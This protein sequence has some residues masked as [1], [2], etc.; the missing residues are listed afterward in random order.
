MDTSVP[1]DRDVFR[2]SREDKWRPSAME[3]FVSVSEDHEQEAM[4]AVDHMSSAAAPATACIH[5]SVPEVNSADVGPAQSEEEKEE[6]KGGES[7]WGSV[8]QGLWSKRTALFANSEVPP[9]ENE[10]S[11]C[12]VGHIGGVRGMPKVGFVKLWNK[13]EEFWNTVAQTAAAKVAGGG[14]GLDCGGSAAGPEQRVRMQ[15]PL[16]FLS[17]DEWLSLLPLQVCTEHTWMFQTIF[18]TLKHKHYTQKHLLGP[19]PLSSK[20][21]TS[22][23]CPRCHNTAGKQLHNLVFATSARR[24]SQGGRKTLESKNSGYFRF[25]GYFCSLLDDCQTL[26]KQPTLSPQNIYLYGQRLIV[27]G[28]RQRRS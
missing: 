11:P 10:T 22:T 4:A 26:G 2:D 7:G 15:N 5:T 9:L 24:G 3:A 16:R 1:D 23:T 12:D 13:R 27:G 6:E 17:R 14:D 8:V 19:F 21:F 25:V 28:A 20:I 18:W